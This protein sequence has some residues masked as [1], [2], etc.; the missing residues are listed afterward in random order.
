MPYKRL[1]PIVLLKDGLLVRSQLFKY[2]Q[3]I[4]DPIPTIK[5]LSDWGV[6]E[7]ILL[8]IGMTNNFD[9]R[10]DDKWHNI[11][12]SNFHNLINKISKFCFAPL[13]VG[14]YIRNKTD[15]KELFNSGAD[16][17][18]MNTS[19]FE[20]Q[21]LVEWAVKEYGS[22]SIVAS[23]DIKRV[24][25]DYKIITNNG[26]K[27]LNLSMSEAIEHCLNIGVGEILISSINY[28]GS[29]KGYD[30]YIL[31]NVPS[32]LKIP[33]IINSGARYTNH[34]VEA[35]EKDSIQA[36]AASNIFYFTELSYPI[37]KNKINK[38]VNLLRKSELLSDLINRE[39]K[40]SEIEKKKLLSK[41]NEGQFFDK[42]KFDGHLKIKPKYCRRC[43]YP[44]LS[45]SPMQFNDEGIC[46]GCNIYE[47]KSSINEEEF[48]NRKKTLLKIAE[49][50]RSNSNYDCIVSV[51][52]GKDSYYQ[53]HFVKNE[54]NLNPLL[55][56]Y[57]G[58]NFTEEG[59]DNLIRMKDV[60]KCDHI[61]INPS[62]D[63]L[64]KLN[65]ISFVVM[66]D[67]NWHNHIGLYTAAPRVAIQYKIPL[68]FWGEHGYADLCGQFSDEDYPEMN[69]RERLEHA[70]RGFDWNFFV[71]IDD[72]TS[73]DMFLWKYPSDSEILEL[74]LRQ[75]Y[76][77]N[78]VKWESNNHLKMMIEKYNF[79]VSDKK[80]ERTYRK[81]S[82]LD[83]IYENGIHDYMKYIKF[84][85]GRCTDHASK[86]IR[87][88][89][90]S[91][92]EGIKL[93]NS[94]DHIKSRDLYRWLDYVGMTEKEFDRIADHFRDPR[95]W[96]WNE[97]SG[98]RRDILTTGKEL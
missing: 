19:L 66:G 3:A 39:P 44:S 64:K 54:L 15:L 1:I 50:N 40:Y 38:A 6:D 67:M 71:G 55:V 14:G 77:G 92:R 96:T 75:I 20:N 84:G 60:F 11:G 97:K 63:I 10:R 61:I 26:T 81:G 76:L 93:I 69:Y 32:D 57:N 33:I 24:K 95:V 88:G 89:L 85:Y 45:A 13:S 82:N 25:S 80:F 62:V 23:L 59:W 70:G 58:N 86:D 16:K 56:T 49:Q 48:N 98:W 68:I 52:G 5:R 9:S 43:L 30:P 12:Q 53:T 65:K 72:I 2:H 29:T 31:Q 18:I 87:A 8:N 34:F 21:S 22:Q 7:M 73:K 17:C 36:V 41:E 74:D 47:K 83:D 4:G 78:Y 90:I 91:R 42:K 28:D 27:L 94:M 46:M 79:K 35:L 51:S 37:I